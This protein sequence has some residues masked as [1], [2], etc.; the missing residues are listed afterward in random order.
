MKSFILRFKEVSYIRKSNKFLK[1]LRILN[2]DVTLEPKDTNLSHIY[3]DIL[4]ID[5]TSLSLP[6]GALYEKDVP[7]TAIEHGFITI[8]YK[9]TK[10]YIFAKGCEG[11]YLSC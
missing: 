11:S 10:Y 4:G 5:L 3:S 7:C 2:P 1:Y 9:K 8:L 6:I